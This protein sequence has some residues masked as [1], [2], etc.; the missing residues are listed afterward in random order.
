MSARNACHEVAENSSIGPRPLSV[1]S[2]TPTMEKDLF[3]L[4]EGTGRKGKPSV[5]LRVATSLKSSQFRNWNLI[6]EAVG[7][8]D[9][10]RPAARPTIFSDF[11][12]LRL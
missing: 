11:V 6:L 3:R 8:G 2:R 4:L 1:V 7:R 10:V 5:L 9:R 12:S